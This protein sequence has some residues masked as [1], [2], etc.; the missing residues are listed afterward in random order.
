MTR[1][2]NIILGTLGLRGYIKVWIIVNWIK[3]DWEW[4]SKKSQRELA[5]CLINALKTIMVA[6]KNFVNEDFEFSWSWTRQRY[7]CNT[8]KKKKKV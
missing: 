7:A 3:L 6:K 2:I 5:P 8:G 1:P 4:A